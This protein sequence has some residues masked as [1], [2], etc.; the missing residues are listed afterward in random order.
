MQLKTLILVTCAVRRF[1]VLNRFIVETSV[2]LLER[3][4]LKVF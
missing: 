2:N 3:V 1:N 4:N